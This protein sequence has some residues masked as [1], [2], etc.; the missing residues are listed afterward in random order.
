MESAAYSFTFICFQPHWFAF[1]EEK[2]VD[3]IIIVAPVSADEIIS[4]DAKTMQI[5]FK[6]YNTNI[7]NMLHY[8]KELPSN[9]RQQIKDILKD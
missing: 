1:A 3:E 8:K 2:N 5:T 7:N 9:W 4:I 6:W